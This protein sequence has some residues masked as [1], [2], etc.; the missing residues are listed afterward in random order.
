MYVSVDGYTWNVSKS[1]WWWIGYVEVNVW[2][3]TREEGRD[4]YTMAK[5][6]YQPWNSISNRNSLR[7][8]LASST[9]LVG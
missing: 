5:W 1:V 2:I 7:P 3:D 4:M 6:L 8:S 9:I